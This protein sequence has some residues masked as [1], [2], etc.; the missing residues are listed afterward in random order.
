MEISEQTIVELIRGQSAT[1]QA[2]V[3]LKASL[4]KTLPYLLA[5][6][7]ENAQNIQSVRNKMYYF[8]GAGTVVGY[9]ASKFGV[10][11]FIT[12]FGGK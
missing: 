2:V 7:K 11:H 12:L 1:T 8:S 9:L 5:N 3:D 10:E 6:D 4:D